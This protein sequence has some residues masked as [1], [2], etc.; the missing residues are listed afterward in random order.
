MYIKKKKN[1]ILFF[2]MIFGQ[3]FF[4][5]NDFKYLSKTEYKKEKFK[6]QTS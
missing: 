5:S 2:Q 4:F 1:D 6:P 3:R